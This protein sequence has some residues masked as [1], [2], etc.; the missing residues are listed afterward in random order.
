M[1]AVHRRTFWII[2][3]ARAVDGAQQFLRSTYEDFEWFFG[4]AADVTKVDQFGTQGEAEKHATM[5]LGGTT[6][7]WFASKFEILE[8]S[9]DPSPHRVDVVRR[10]IGGIV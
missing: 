1:G 10:R 3:S 7:V 9:D 6:I 2:E 8:G 5:L 4:F